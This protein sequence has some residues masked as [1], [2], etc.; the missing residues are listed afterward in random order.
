MLCNTA[1]ANAIGL[2]EK[3]AA[4]FLP[5]LSVPEPPPAGV[6]LEAFGFDLETIRGTYIEPTLAQVRT[7]D[8]T[9]GGIQLL[10][11]KTPGAPRDLIPVGLGDLAVK[12]GPTYYRYEP[13]Q[14]PKPA[15]IVRNRGG[16]LPQTFV[17]GEPVG[18]SQLKTEKLSEYAGRYGSDELAHDVEIRLEGSRLAAGPVGGAARS[19]RFTPIARDLFETDDESFRFSD[20][21]GWRFERNAR[22]KI[23]RLVVSTDRAW[24]VVLVRR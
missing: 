24:N 14:G 1:Q 3:V 5:E 8:T 15:R 12:G 13:A 16:E 10:V 20:E 2:G 11:G 6:P 22:G 21:A 19:A 17:R 18:P 23:V 4:V 7:I 9:D